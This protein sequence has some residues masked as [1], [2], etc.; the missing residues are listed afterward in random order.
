[1]HMESVKLQ[2]Q[3]SETRNL[4]FVNK[5]VVNE[6]HGMPNLSK[7][8]FDTDVMMGYLSQASRSLKIM[9]EC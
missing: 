4:A 7:G 6:L 8:R 5:T 9:D 3:A 2:E 1:M